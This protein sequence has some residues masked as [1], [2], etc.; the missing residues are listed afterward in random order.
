METLMQ[1]ETHC[2]GGISEI[3]LSENGITSEGVKHL[4]SLLKQ[5]IGRFETLK[6]NDRKMHSVSCVAL[7]HFIP[8]MPHLKFV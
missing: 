2:M 7:V 6:L 1:G 3:S 5:L 4:S 8:H